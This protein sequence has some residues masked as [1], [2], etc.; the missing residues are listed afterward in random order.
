MDFSTATKLKLALATSS[1]TP[2][3]LHF[4]IESLCI[5]QRAL[6]ISLLL[7]EKENIEPF[8][9]SN[10]WVEERTQVINSLLAAL[11]VD[12]TL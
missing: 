7:E 9:N 10:I 5:K 3:E 2:E 12:T 4:L 8:L 6:L 1:K 11:N